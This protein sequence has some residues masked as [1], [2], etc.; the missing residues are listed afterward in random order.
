M[1][2]RIDDR[3]GRIDDLLGVLRKPVF[4]RIG[5]E[6]AL[7]GGYSAGGHHFT[8][9][10][11]Y[12]LFAFVIAS[13]A[14]QSILV[15]W[16]CGLLRCARNDGITSIAL[17]QT[18]SRMITVGV[19]GSVSLEI[20]SVRSLRWSIWNCWPIRRMNSSSGVAKRC[21]GSTT[22]AR[23]RFVISETPSS[24]IV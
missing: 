14:K 6:P 24:D 16:L 11:C 20:F 1:V 9:C 8:P 23:R 17:S 10:Y 7:G 2:M 12:R 3:A 15:L 4:A 21:I 13:A 5:I 18:P 22:E 19:A